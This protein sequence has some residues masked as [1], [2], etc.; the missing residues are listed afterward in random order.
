MT[1]NK[2]LLYFGI[3]AILFIG[4]KFIYS[5][6]G[7]EQLWWLLRPTKALVETL[8]GS[9]ASYTAEQGYFFERLNIVIDKSCSG[10]NFWLICFM[11]LVYLILSARPQLKG[12]ILVIPLALFIAYG[13]TLFVNSSRILLAITINK[14][15]II[16]HNIPWLHEAEGAFVY[17]FFLTMIYLGLLSSLKT[18]KI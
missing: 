11:L 4:L 12:R 14:L 9:R 15:A 17:L 18:R 2:N 10:F 5:M 3:S 13:L 16:P 7:I 8:T 6:L 1:Q